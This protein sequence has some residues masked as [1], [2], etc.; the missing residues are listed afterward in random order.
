MIPAII[1]LVVLLVTVRNDNGGT[2]VRYATTIARLRASGETVRIV[3]RCDSACTLYLGLPSRQLCIGRGVYFRFH[4]PRSPS[5]QAAKVARS[6]MMK[7]YPGWV[8][9]WIRSKGGLSRTLITMD[10]GYARAFIRTCGL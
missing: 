2:I 5:E 10:Y 7:K 1:L 8:R 4:A 3:G 9:S 6:Y